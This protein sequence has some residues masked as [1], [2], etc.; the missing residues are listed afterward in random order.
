MC[1]TE[2]ENHSLVKVGKKEKETE[3]SLSEHWRLL[4]YQILHLH[5]FKNLFM[6]NAD[7]G[8]WLQ[9]VPNK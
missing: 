7:V 5:P 8:E 2:Y 3:I 9:I 4:K 6:D 1:L